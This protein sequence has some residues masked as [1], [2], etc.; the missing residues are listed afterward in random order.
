MIGDDHRNVPLVGPGD[1]AQTADAVVHGDDQA[2]PTG[3]RL[4]DDLGG[5][6]VAAG[7]AVGHQVLHR[8]GAESAQSEHAQSRGGGA[9]GVVV[10]DHDDAGSQFQAA[11]QQAQRIVQTTQPG[12]RQHG[13]QPEIEVGRA[14]HAPGAVDLFEQQRQVAGEGAGILR[15]S[16]AADRFFHR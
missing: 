6:A 8:T 9:V 13:V 7:K 15:R 2:G 11:L 14:T 10:A 5:Q 4:I 16:P 3:G 1:A 12:G